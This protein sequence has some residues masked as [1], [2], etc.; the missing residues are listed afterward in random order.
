MAQLLEFTNKGIYCEIG[1]FYID[2]LKPVDKALI[3]HAHADHSRWGNKQYI[4]HRLSK[5]V[6]LHR[7][8]N[9]NVVTSVEY[10]EKLNINGIKVSF[11][12]AGH[13]PGSSQIRL[14]YKGEVWVASGDYKIEEDSIST[15]F[16]PIKCNT[17]ITEST[18]GLPVFRWENQTKV[19]EG[20]N[21]W[22]KKKLNEG[23]NSI[24]LAYSLGKAQRLLKH[25]NTE[26]GNIWLHGAVYN[27]NEVL[28]EAGIEGIN[29]PKLPTEASK[30]KVKGAMI[31]APPSV[32]GS[33]WIRKLAPFSVAMA[34]GW[35]AMRGTKNRRGVDMGFVLSDHAD[36][37]GLNWAINETEAENIIVTHGYTQ[38]FATWLCEKGLNAKAVE[39]MY[40]DENE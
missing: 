17:F 23:K 22:W 32:M 27:I 7:L 8:G 16:E 19:F 20:I 24:I 14:E 21:N 33:P 11:H 31:I 37:D 34:S 29:F 1:D 26:L 30:N 4:A 18:F 28:V 5:P 9:N 35:M 12:P 38:Q 10:Q 13:I 6:I 25:L 40:N 2:P 15:P 36:W 3:T 39:N